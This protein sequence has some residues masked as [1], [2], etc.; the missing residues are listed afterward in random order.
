LFKQYNVLIVLLIT[1]ILLIMLFSCKEGMFP[2]ELSIRGIPAQGLSGDVVTM[3]ETGRD[4]RILIRTQVTGKTL[5]FSP[6][7][8]TELFRIVPDTLIAH[9]IFEPDG[10]RR[11]VSFYQDQKLILLVCDN[12][13]H[14]PPPFSHIRLQPGNRINGK[15]LPGREW[16]DVVMFLQG[17]ETRLVPGKPIEVPA[18]EDSIISS[19]GEKWFFLLVG[20]SIWHGEDNVDPAGWHG[21]SP[22]G[23]HGISPAGWDGISPAGWDGMSPAGDEGSPG[24]GM[25]GKTAGEEPEFRLD[26]ILY[27]K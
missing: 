27:G 7:I 9:Q 8:K 6:W 10:P 22:A 24:N 20:A 13:Q 3:A 12:I 5:I 26:C 16:V 1:G 23:W 25:S 14:L 21:I 15:E 19:H 18:G 17:K 2:L 4:L 11:Y